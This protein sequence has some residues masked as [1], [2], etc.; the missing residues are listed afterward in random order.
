[1]KYGYCAV[2]RVV[3]GRLAG[4]AVF[5]LHPHQA[6]FRLPES[7]L[8]PLPETLPPERGVLAANME[9]ALMLL[10]DGGAGPGDRIAV[11]GAGVVGGLVAYL[12]ARLPG[13][14]VTLVDTNPDRAALA[15]ALGC[16]F[17]GPGAAPAECDLVLHLSATAPGL[18]TAIACA[19]QE[20]TVIEGSWHGAG[21]TEVPL[22]GAF[23]SRRLRLVGSQVG[24]IPPT[25]APRWSYARRIAKALELLADPAL[26]ALFSG[27]TAF[28]DLPDRYGA[29][30]SDPAT[31]CHRICYDAQ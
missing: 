8:T 24:Q 19:G 21:T 28:A 25:R 20:A 15:K 29:I 2:G 27:E 6:R 10:W 31:L 26:D 12:A 22:G 17:A 13:A 23:H 1:V 18:A 16:H 5:A 9:T 11:I 14:D 7:A 3:E 4:Q 30:L